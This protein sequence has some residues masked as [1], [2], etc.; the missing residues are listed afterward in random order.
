VFRDQDI[1]DDVQAAYSRA[2]GPLELT[3]VSS[4][5]QNTFY[6][7]ITNNMK[8]QIVPPTIARSWSPRP[9]RSGTPI[10]RSRRRRRWLRC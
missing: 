9:M 5:G 4:L 6:S 3:K 8:G 10:P 7:R 1:A 2:F